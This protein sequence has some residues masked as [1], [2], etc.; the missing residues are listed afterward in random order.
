MSYKFI[1]TIEFK[2]DLKK[3]D[4]SAV[5]LILKYIKRVENSENPKAYGKELSGNMVGLYRFRVNDY[6]I[7]AKF[8]K[9]TFIVQ[10]LGVGHRKNIYKILEGRL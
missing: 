1:P 4:G 10:G 8:V 3:L 9:D 6:R 5:K 2:E 7:V